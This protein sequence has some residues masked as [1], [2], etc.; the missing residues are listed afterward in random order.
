ME[1]AMRWSVRIYG[2]LLVL[3]PREL[4]CRFGA[5]MVEVFEDV[6]RAAMV[7]RG[8]SGVV[9]LWGTALWELTSVGVRS[10]LETATIVVVTASFAVSSFIAWIFFR[11]VG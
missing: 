6:L 2:C 1:T 10:R 7:E 9:D 11:A 5:D 4:R 8:G 3:Y